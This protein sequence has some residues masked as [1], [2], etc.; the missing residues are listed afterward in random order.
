[1]FDIKIKI[2]GNGTLDFGSSGRLRLGT[3]NENQRIKLVFDIDD[4]V[5]GTYQY[6]KFVNKK[7]TYLYRVYSKEIILSRNIQVFDG[8]WMF[9][10]ISTNAG[11][12]NNQ[13]TGTYAFITEPVE[14]VVVKGI[15]GEV[16]QTDE[17]I[18]LN[19]LCSMIYTSLNLPASVTSIGDY[20]MYNS[21]RT[22]SLVIGEDITSI[23]SYAFYDAVITSLTFKENSSLTTL[24][25]YALYHLTINGDVVFP[26]TIS[27][28]GQYVLKNTTVN[29]ISFEA[30]SNLKVLNAYAFREINVKEVYLPDKLTTIN[31]NAFKTCTLLTKLWIPN[32]ITSDIAHTAIAGCDA[33]SE[34]V[35]EAGFEANAYFD[36][37]NLTQNSMV[38]MLYSLKNKRPEAPG[39]LVLGT[40]NLA[41][42]TTDQKAIAV[43]KNWT[44]S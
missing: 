3:T 7:A 19:S 13:I 4:T 35:L 38:T 34:I 25:D 11:I 31:S 24:R 43:N 20:F 32:T 21:K 28:W 27:S 39:K 22:F 16:N 40:T 17:E 14:A 12:V 9:S 26:R 18:V 23:G 2:R 30:D 36:N 8:I 37:C 1:M 5:E 44:L 10:F 33:L 15:L 42:L 41:K 29:K 6:I